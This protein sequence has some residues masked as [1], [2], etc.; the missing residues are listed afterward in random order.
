MAQNHE[1]VGPDHSP[2]GKPLF[3]GSLGIVLAIVGIMGHPML[4]IYPMWIFTHL[5]RDRLRRMVRGVPFSVSFIGFGVI[6]GLLTEIFAIINN[7]TLPPEKRILLAPDPLLDLIYGFFF[8]FLFMAV[9]CLL[10]KRFTYSKKEVFVIAGLYGI[11]TEEVGQVLVRVFT[12]PVTG[13]LYAIIVSFVYGIFPLLAYVI[14]EEKLGAKKGNLAVRSL[15]ATLA[16]FV[17]WAAYG[18]FI[19]PALKKVFS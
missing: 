4:L 12:V 9:W 13:F 18:L 16:L 2:P 17:E 10:I 1:H 5:N 3:L 8:Y 15:V 6:F 11:C 19:L 7:S 14:S